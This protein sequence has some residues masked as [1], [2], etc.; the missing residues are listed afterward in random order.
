MTILFREGTIGWEGALDDAVLKYREH[1]L[2]GLTERKIE[3]LM[4][5][6]AVHI[7]VSDWSRF[8]DQVKRRFEFRY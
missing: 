1:R 3:M 6:K 7:A 2:M 4:I 5:E 8:F